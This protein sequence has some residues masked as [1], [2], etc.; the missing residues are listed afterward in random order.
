[1]KTKN[2]QI[3]KAQKYEENY[4]KMHHSEIAQC[5]DKEKTPKSRQRERRPII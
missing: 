3:R 4:T 2:G 5:Y 1:M